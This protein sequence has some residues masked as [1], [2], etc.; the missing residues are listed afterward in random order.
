MKKKT[1]LLLILLSLC[2]ALFCDVEEDEKL[3]A[4]RSVMA[5]H[6]YETAFL[7]A[8]QFLFEYPNSM[9]SYEARILLSEVHLE[10]GYYSEARMQIMLLL[11]N[12]YQMTAIQRARTYYLLAISFYREKNYLDAI[13]T[14][15]RLF[16]DYKE[17]TVAQNALSTYFECFFTIADYQDAI[18]K[19]RELQKGYTD[20]DIL[21]ELL[22]QQ[23]R[24]HYHTNMIDSAKSL[25]T[26][27]TN[28]YPQTLAAAKSIELQIMIVEKEYG[29]ITATQRLEQDLSRTVSREI[30][31]RLTWLLINYYIRQNQTA[32]ATEK[33]DFLLGRFSLS[34]SLSTYYLLWLELMLDAKNHRAILARE[35]T[36]LK[37][38][39]NSPE[40]YHIYLYLAKA[41]VQVPD[42][43][44]ARNILDTHIGNVRDETLKFEYLFLYADIYARQGQYM[45]SI[46]GYYALLNQYS[47][48]GKN[49]DVLMQ[50]GHLHLNNMNQPTQALSFYRQAVGI[51][52]TADQTAEALESCSRCQEATG[53]Y[54]EAFVSLEQIPLEQMSDKTRAENLANRMTL[55]HIFYVSDTS[56]TLTNFL[57]LGSEVAVIDRARVIALNAKQFDNAMTLLKTQNTHESRIERIKLYFLFAYKALLEGNNTE[58]ETNLTLIQ[59]ERG[60][61]GRN[62]ST[63]DQYL[64][65]ALNDF[66]NN[67]GKLTSRNL[68]PTISYINAPKQNLTGI[69]LQNFFTYHLCLF[70]VDNNQKNEM[71]EMAVKV[72]PDLF[73]SNVDFQKINIMLASDYYQQ[74]AYAQ[75]L[76][77][78]AKAERFQS[79]S[80][81]DYYY[82]YAMS[83]YETRNTDRALDILQRLVLN[84]I[85]FPDIANA[86]KTILTHW[87]SLRPPRLSDALDVLN[88]IP[89]LKRTD[90]DYRYF[91]TIYNRQNDMPKEKENLLMIQQRTWAETQRLATLHYATGDEAMAEATWE[92]ILQKDSDKTDKLNAYAGLGHMKYTAKKYTEAISRYEQFFSLYTNNLP[93]D[94]F[95]MSPE[96]VAKELVMCCYLADNKTKAETHKRNQQNLLRSPE[97]NREITMYEGYYY[98]NVEPKRSIR[99]L[100]SVIEANPTPDN[101]TY[102]AMYYRGAANIKDK[103]L[104][105]A[106]KDL[107]AAMAISD[108]TIKNDVRL[109]LG[110]LY[111][112]Q[113]NYSSALDCYY[114]VIVTDVDGYQARDASNNFAIVAREVQAYDRAIGAYKIIMERWGQSHLTHEAR[115]TIGFCFY[116][117]RQYDQ[118]LNLLNQ[119]FDELTR[120]ALK[121]ETL[122]WIGESYSGKRDF[123]EAELAW[124][125]I[126]TQFSSEGRW[127][128]V[129]R[130]RIAEN[131]YTQGDVERAKGL[132]NEI[133]RTYGA[134]SDEGREAKRY[135]DAM[136]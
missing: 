27:I 80:Y 52:K 92:E 118:A 95:S 32:K 119:L 103:N 10:R 69:N 122:Y 121:A 134:G 37:I 64:M 112:S 35:E 106:E 33:L 44:A 127:V 104:E 74:N 75:A 20:P 5:E 23:A 9:N 110:N 87:F 1:I 26:E 62:I 29:I 70:Y 109:S 84:H 57:M 47:S 50:L 28:K 25:I 93:N 7:Y 42:L 131:A 115:L 34:E 19:S 51:A 81:P 133:L 36:I 46:D 123:I 22:Y 86:R 100:T 4:I 72:V 73:V 59:S 38:S 39:R 18:I 21:A 97:T 135:L 105:A 111:Y 65:L 41:H 68:A 2:L 101:I 102:Q 79:L 60:Q 96:T 8:N 14:F 40:A 11:S 117:A 30:E 124:N 67:K 126:R 130:L 108:T 76:T 125:R 71:R 98:I 24:A 116:Q 55:L 90:E 54:A 12:P 136:N 49:Y 45:N 53:Q 66:L 85:D 78:F 128:G 129:S 61:L 82:Q 48:V 58:A 83:L 114:T 99:L 17:T 89:P 56:S 16:L 107:I 120:N 43:W 88:Q 3:N 113:Q 13:E 31:E 15:D 6:D 94:G 132:F 77:Y 63:N 91:V